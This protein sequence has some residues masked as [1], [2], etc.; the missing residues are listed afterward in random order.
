MAL[1]VLHE[2]LDQEP[3]YRRLLASLRGERPRVDLQLLT[4]AAPFVLS[5][6]SRG[7]GCPMVV[8]APKPEEA[9]RLY[10]QI[11]VWAGPETAVLHF[12]ETEALPFERV[13]SD[14]D[15]VHQRIGTLARLSG[16]EP[17]VVVVAS[18]A[19][20]VQ[21]TVDRAPLRVVAAH[22]C[23]GRDDRPGVAARPVAQDG[24]PVRAQR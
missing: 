18:V 4:N 21:S 19:A 2:L 14:D 24:L 23:P 9:R 20:L 1:D 5:S 15:T 3:R 13:M 6:I 10:E 17:N 12:P 22:A 7:L 11:T 16:G 8:V